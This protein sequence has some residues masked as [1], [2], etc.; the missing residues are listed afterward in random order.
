MGRR[1]C[2]LLERWTPGVHVLGAARS[3][4]D[5][6]NLAVRSLNVA[7]ESSVRAAL[8]GVTLLINAV[9]PYTYDPGP[10]IRACVGAGTHYAD[11][12]DDEG[13]FEF[14]LTQGTT[15]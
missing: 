13:W 6:R 11:L 1:I 10:V 9:G 8:E 7:E 12:A 3:A 14:P 2:R 5:D 15:V 4:S